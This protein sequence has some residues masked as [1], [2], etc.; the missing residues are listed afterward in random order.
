MSYTLPWFQCAAALEHL[1][2]FHFQQLTEERERPP[3]MH[4]QAHLQKDPALFSGQLEVLL[5]M[6][7]FEDCAN[8][9]S[10]S[11]PLLALILTSND[12]FARWKDEVL[13]LQAGNPDRQQKLKLAFEKLMTDVQPNLEAKNRD[14]FTQNLTLFR[15]DMK[16]IF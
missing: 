15:H 4:L 11:R 6:V 10:L 8:Q 12:F 7:V 13:S 16:N 9:W 3:K 5:H 2:A 14:R 1:A